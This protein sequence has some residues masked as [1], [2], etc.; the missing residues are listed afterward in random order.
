ML[1]SIR[2][3]IIAATAGCLV[4]ALLLNTIM[5]YQVTRLDNQQ[6]SLNTLRSTSASHNLAIGDWV[7]GKI[8]MIQSLDTVALGADPVPVFTQMAKAG[9]FMNVYVG[10]AA[11]TAKFSNPEGVPADY[12]PTIRPW[13]QQAVKADAP[14]VTAPYVD[15]GTVK[16]VVTFAVPVKRA[17]HSPH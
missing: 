9:G 3:R 13:Y 1:T 6:A 11:K 2:A 10:Y 4:G 14:V 12:D 7:S 16:P 17:Q 15:A 8:A 5:N